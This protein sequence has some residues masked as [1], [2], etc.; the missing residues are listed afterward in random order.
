MDIRLRPFADTAR[1][2]A[3]AASP[4]HGRGLL[5]LAAGL[6]VTL[7][8]GAVS[9]VNLAIP[10]LSTGPSAPSAREVL[11][12]V[13]GYVAVFA[14]LLV[15]A[16]A[17]SD[18]VGRKRVLLTGLGLFTAGSAMCACA[19]GIGQLIAGRVV[20]GVGAAGILPN[21]LALMTHGVSG[22]VRQRAVAVWA[23]MTGLAAVAG[24]IGGGAALE[25]GSWRTLFVA[26][27]VLG[28]LA[29]GVVAIAAPAPPRH[30]RSLPATGTCLLA[31]GVLALLYAILGGS[32]SG[33]SSPSI[34]GAAV[35]A[36]LALVAWAIHEL[37][38]P[39]PLLDPRLF[40]RPAV[41]AGAFGMAVVFLGLFGLLYINGQYLQ[42]T[43]GYGPLSA[44]LRLLPMA[45]ALLA[46]PRCAPL[47]RRMTGART[48]VCLGM[49]VMATG[50][51]VVA[52]VTPDTPYWRYAAGVT[53]TALGCGIATP[54]LSHAIVVAL[55]EERAAAGSALQSLSRE[56]GS[57]LGIAVTGS[58][59]AGAFVRRLPPA[60]GDGG[61]PPTTVPAALAR[62]GGAVAEPAITHAFTGA[63]GVAM[64]VL[65]VLTAASAALLA[66]WFP[67]NVAETRD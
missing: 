34:V 32:E 31:G 50:L 29:A 58:V 54:V 2:A 59:M 40:V 43:K 51:G 64:P 10:A 17:L 22:A 24:N 37:R 9:A 44:G 65:A 27:A 63:L 56:L 62:P 38:V 25:L 7:V 14:C 33:W 36:C 49:L 60:I 20:S 41:G 46:G 53:V 1:P 26:M 11:W 21:T 42:Y 45:A 3:S 28:P 6:C 61:N 67:R 18:R 30:H 5:T 4:R 39:Q 15:P 35:A 66:G 13:D 12:A 19:P 52:T 16:G 57:A 55:P 23:S 8:V 47:V 48:T